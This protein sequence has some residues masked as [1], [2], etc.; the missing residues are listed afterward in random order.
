MAGTAEIPNPIYAA[1]NILEV[2]GKSERA[3]PK[4]VPMTTPTK[5]IAQKTS[6]PG[7]SAIF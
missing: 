7:T 4:P 5:A 2:R 6:M 1:G 3:R